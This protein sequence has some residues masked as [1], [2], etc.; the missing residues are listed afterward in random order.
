[1]HSGAGALAVEAQTGVVLDAVDKSYGTVAA[2]RGVT[3]DIGAGEFVAVVGPSGC[4]KSTLLELVCG[5]TRP[6]RAA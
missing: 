5:L 6:M 3:L 4:G 2:L 1:M